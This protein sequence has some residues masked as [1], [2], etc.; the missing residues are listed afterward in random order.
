MI[1]AAVL[2]T[3]QVLRN[4][5]SACMEMRLR[6][7]RPAHRNPRHPYQPRHPSHPLDPYRA[8]LPRRTAT[9]RTR[10]A[11]TALTLRNLDEYLTRGTLTTPVVAPTR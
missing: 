11:M 10:G 5:S 1:A 6:P 7:D 3:S 9:A 2:T 4:I 8:W